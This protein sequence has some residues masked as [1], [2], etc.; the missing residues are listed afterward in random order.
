MMMNN[1][2]MASLFASIDDECGGGNRWLDD[3]GLNIYVS[4]REKK[5][6]CS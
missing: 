1:H 6:I 5:H 4:E 3:V 2:C